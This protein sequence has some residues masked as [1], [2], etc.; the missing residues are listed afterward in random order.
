VGRAGWI[1]LDPSPRLPAEGGSGLGAVGL[2]LD[3]LRVRWHRYVINWS[4]RDQLETAMALRQHA[5]SAWGRGG[6]W[7]TS[8]RDV[9]PG[10]TARA[11]AAV[12][13]LLGGLVV[14]RWRRAAASRRPAGGRPLPP[15]YA[16]AL[17]SLARSGLAP[18][19]GETARE[20][21]ARVAGRAPECAGPLGTLTA[22]YER[23][24]FGARPPSPGDLTELS[25]CL[26]ALDRAR[27]RA[28]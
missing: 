19:S 17:R 20:F 7:L 13:V 18:A 1:T 16:R 5:T 26:T 6:P 21:C 23:G 24:R 3:A 14:W 2:H 4:L 15:Y 27:P 22:A 10:P 8:L 9:Q 28:H 25:A 11:V 12:G